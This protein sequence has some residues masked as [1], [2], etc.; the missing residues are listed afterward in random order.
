MQQSNLQ[1]S[2]WQPC[3]G[4]SPGIRSGGGGGGSGSSVIGHLAAHIVTTIIGIIRIGT[5]TGVSVGRQLHIMHAHSH[6]CI[7]RSSAAYHA[8]THRLISM[9]RVSVTPATDRL[10]RSYAQLKIPEPVA[11]YSYDYIN[12]NEISNT[13]TLWQPTKNLHTQETA[14]CA[15]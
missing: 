4:I 13:C 8:C 5:A 3:L 11:T 9:C 10:M 1:T 14:Q 12:Q 15:R 6:R 7:G 2:E